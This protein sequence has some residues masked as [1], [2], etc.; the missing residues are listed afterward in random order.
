MALAPLSES[1]P[2]RKMAILGAG[3]ELVAIRG[4][5]ESDSILDHLYRHAERPDFQVRF[6]WR[7]HSVAFWD[8]RCVQHLALW[9]YFPQVRSG[10]RV[11]IKGDRPF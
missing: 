6:Q 7:P 11:T 5:E 9:D 2:A 3:I 1:E 10:R 8:N 4:V